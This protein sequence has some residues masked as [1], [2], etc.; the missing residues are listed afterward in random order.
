MELRLTD[1]IVY[2]GVITT[3]GVMCILISTPHDDLDIRKATKTEVKKYHNR[4]EK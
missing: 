3:W 1:I 2:E 4:P